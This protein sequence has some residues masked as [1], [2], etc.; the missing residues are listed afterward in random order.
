MQLQVGD[1]LVDETGE[2][3]IIGHPYTTNAGKDAHARVQKAGEPTVT[4]IRT[5]SAHER[6]SVKRASDEEGKR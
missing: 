6:I 1:R 2:L 5:W 3:E 4:E